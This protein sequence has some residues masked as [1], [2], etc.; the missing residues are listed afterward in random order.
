MQSLTRAL[1]ARQ[2]TTEVEIIHY[3]DILR[4]CRQNGRIDR[5]VHAYYRQSPLGGGLIFA[6]FRGGARRFGPP[7]N[8]PLACAVP[9]ACSGKPITHPTVP[10]GFTVEG[11]FTGHPLTALGSTDGATWLPATLAET[12]D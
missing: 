10:H 5:A 9:L 12:S 6:A 2:N 3:E 8:T 1:C 11:T 4:C 7:L